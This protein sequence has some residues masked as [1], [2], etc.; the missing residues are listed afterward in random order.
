M[1]E[2]IFTD[3]ISQDPYFLPSDEAVEKAKLVLECFVEECFSPDHFDDIDC[4]EV[5]YHTWQK[6]VFITSDSNCEPIKQLTC[7]KC[8]EII[9]L[10]ELPKNEDEMTWWEILK[11]NLHDESS[12][13]VTRIKTK[14]PCCQKE[15]LATEID[16]G[17]KA[18]FSKFTFRLRDYEDGL[19]DGQLLVLE[20]I[21]GCKLT[22][23]VSVD[24]IDD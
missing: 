6:P 2:I 19:F 7:P 5:E 11:Q 1:E 9:K 10:F 8:G 23:I 18:G 16:F 4:D 14:M 20:R 15:V 21:L 22:S 17:D 12:D 24:Y 13:D 3:V